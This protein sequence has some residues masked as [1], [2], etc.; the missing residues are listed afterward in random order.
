MK[1]C[2]ILLTNNNMKGDL[3]M[4]EQVKEFKEGAKDVLVE[5]KNRVSGFVKKYPKIYVL[6]PVFG[7]IIGH[8]AGTAIRGQL[9]TGLTLFTVMSAA[10]AT[11][12]TGVFSGAKVYNKE[13]NS[14]SKKFGAVASTLSVVLA[15][16]VAAVETGM[17]LGKIRYDQKNKLEEANR[18]TSNVIMIDFNNKSV[19]NPQVEKMF[20]SFKE[21]Q[22]KK[23]QISPLSQYMSPMKR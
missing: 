21:E 11:L 20:K 5:M 4:K 17:A 10:T 12:L 14:L 3:Q 16:G 19:N 18:Q 8:I 2:A 9:A 6:T 7:G 22:I 15:M 13:K 1:R 23:G